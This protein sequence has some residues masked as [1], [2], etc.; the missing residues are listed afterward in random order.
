MAQND[1]KI[2]CTW[3]TCQGIISTWSHR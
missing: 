3:R 2:V 1:L